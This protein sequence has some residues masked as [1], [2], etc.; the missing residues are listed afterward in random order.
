VFFKWPHI[1]QNALTEDRA[2]QA[3]RIS[4][5]LPMAEI[6]EIKR[7]MVKLKLHCSGEIVDGDVTQS[8]FTVYLGG[9]DW[10]TYTTPQ[11][12]LQKFP[13][14]LPLPQQVFNVDAE[15]LLA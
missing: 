11:H 6:V 1:P 9:F 13:E 14:F 4:R 8:G 5:G 12:L 3:Q 15:D 2:E 10:V 7:R